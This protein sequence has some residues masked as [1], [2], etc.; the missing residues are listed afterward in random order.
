[1]GSFFAYRLWKAQSIQVV[2]Y[3][4]LVLSGA[5]LLS[6]YWIIPLLQSDIIGSLYDVAQMQFFTPMGTVGS[7]LLDTLALNNS[8]MNYKT[9]ALVPVDSV[10]LLSWIFALVYTLLTI[11]ALFVWRRGA[12]YILLFWALFAGFFSLNLA[13]PFLA[14]INLWIFDTIPLF[15]AYREPGKRMALV[16]VFYVICIAV[17][18]TKTLKHRTGWLVK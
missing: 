7:L 13:T 14:S 16:A 1:M 6:L 8:W 17:L 11:G 12:Q 3:G 2:Y 4:L 18:L 10:P 5:V 15:S 9:R